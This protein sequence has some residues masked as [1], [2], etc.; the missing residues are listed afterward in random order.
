MGRRIGK[1]N[2]L[3]PKPVFYVAVIALPLIAVLAWLLWPHPSI[4]IV[5]TASPSCTGLLDGRGCLQVTWSTDI[6]TNAMVDLRQVNAEG[7]TVAS[8]RQPEPLGKDHTL[9]FPAKPGET[10]QVDILAHAKWAQRTPLPTVKVVA[11]SAADSQPASAPATPAAT[12][13][14]ADESK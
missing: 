6:E 14:A 9:T 3:N 2:R 4:P 1:R 8:R 11:R 7:T 13:P 10:W 12:A 5:V